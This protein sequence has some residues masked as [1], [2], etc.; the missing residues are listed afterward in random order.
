MHTISNPK[1]AIA[2]A[3]ALASALVASG[4]SGCGDPPPEVNNPVNHQTTPANNQTTGNN[5]NS[6]AAGAAGCACMGDSTCNDGAMCVDGM[7]VGV[8]ATGLVVDAPDA[9]S[10]ELLLVESAGARV[11]EA[12]FA[13]GTLGAMRRRAPRVALAISRDADADLPESLGALT[14]EGD[15]A[16]IQVDAIT[17]YLADGSIVDGATGALEE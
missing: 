1:T 15:V 12:T 3:L 14:I 16:N 11:L 17:C 8:M 10:C 13:E 9:R 6:C 4:C 2:L 5:R 7:C